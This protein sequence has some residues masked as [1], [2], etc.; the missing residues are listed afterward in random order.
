MRSGV[1]SS[2]VV[3]PSY[4]LADDDIARMLQDSFSSS[5]HDM[6]ARALREEQVEADRLLLA[7][8]SA[9]SADKHLLNEQELVAIE[10]NIEKLNA[11]KQGQDHQAIKAA[12]TAL[13]D[14][15]EEFAAR[16]MDQSVRTALSGK[17]LNDI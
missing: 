4:G 9:L 17:N 5:E 1:E 11:T 6:Q 12:I 16:R 7:I 13:A 15:T 3:K 8:A 2:I 10:A 14:A